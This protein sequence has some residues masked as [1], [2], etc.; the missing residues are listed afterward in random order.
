MHRPQFVWS[1]SEATEDFAVIPYQYDSDTPPEGPILLFDFPDELIISLGGYDMPP[2]TFDYFNPLLVTPDT[3]KWIE[4]YG[5]RTFQ[6]LSMIT[7]QDLSQLMKLT[8][9]Y[10]PRYL[11]NY[12][13]KTCTR[14]AG[15]PQVFLALSIP[16]PLF[17][18]DD[19]FILEDAL[20]DEEE[21]DSPD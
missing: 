10:P 1:A 20:G 18:Y 15:A 3:L 13:A 9:A 7:T 6:C 19:S 12:E 17:I 4:F 16:P 21:L 14:G 2:R 5:P 8:I 11:V